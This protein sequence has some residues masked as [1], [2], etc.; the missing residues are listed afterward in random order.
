MINN[1]L[2]III[3]C[4]N[5]VNDLKKTVED[6]IEKTKINGTTVIIPDFGSNDGSYQYASQASS[7]LIKFLRIESLKMEEN[8][9]ISDLLDRIRTPYIL[10]ITP[11]ST[12]KNNDIILDELNNLF[13]DNCPLA[14]LKKNN[15]LDILFGDLLKN[16]RKI[17]SIFSNKEILS[18]I[19]F[20]TESN[21][22]QLLINNNSL[23]KGIKISGFVN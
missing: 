12:F 10:V 18:D 15:K 20:Y 8:E 17:K 11:G 22:S 13:K 6:L 19:K 3:P 4:K 21:D 16:R 14:Y 7:D 5:S 2:T 1:L 9:D 23:S